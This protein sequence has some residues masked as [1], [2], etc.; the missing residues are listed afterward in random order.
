MIAFNDLYIY[1]IVLN[2]L[3]SYND[4]RKIDLTSRVHIS[5]IWTISGDIK[6]KRK[7]N[8]IITPRQYLRS[9]ETLASYKSP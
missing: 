3:F 7:I 9:L 5:L 4:Y 2:R 6:T 8:E 1:I